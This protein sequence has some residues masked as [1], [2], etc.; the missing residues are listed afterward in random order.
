MKESE[1]EGE[2]E[3]KRERERERER[4]IVTNTIKL[5][6]QKK[7]RRFSHTRVKSLFLKDAAICLRKPQNL[8][9]LS[10]FDEDSQYSRDPH[11]PTTCTGTHEVEVVV[12]GVWL[13]LSDPF[14]AV[15]AGPSSSSWL[16]TSSPSSTTSA[17][18]NSC[19]LI[20]LSP[21]FSPK[22][23]SLNSRVR[24]TVTMDATRDN[25]AKKMYAP[26]VVK[27][28]KKNPTNPAPIKLP[29]TVIIPCHPD[30][31]PN[32]EGC[33]ISGNSAVVLCESGY[34]RVSV[35]CIAGER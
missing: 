12:F 18:N 9:I 34:A 7:T 16:C 14:V 8:F 20:T 33:T 6:P 31:V 5:N 17:L 10:H 1:K 11:R 13:L 21:P 4:E 3:R 28:V 26:V 24:H 25:T 2:C 27:S 30:A 32:C 22:T 15:V 19:N 29:P 23:P 35:V